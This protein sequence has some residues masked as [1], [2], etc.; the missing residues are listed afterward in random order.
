MALFLSTFFV[1]YG[2][3][4]VYAF[5]KAKAAFAFGIRGAFFLGLLMTVMTLAPLIIRLLE[6]HGYDFQARLL[7]Y[8]GYGWM[9]VLLL[10]CSAGIALDIYRLAVHG[11]DLILHRD[12]VFLRP[13]P[14][15]CFVLPLVCA[16]SIAF[17]GYFEARDIQIERITIRTSGIPKSAGTIRIAQI[18]DVHL[19]LIVREGRLERI[20][21]KVKSAEPHIL[22]STGDLVDGQINGLPGLA[23]RLREIDPL[24]GKYAITGNHEFYAGLPQALE[25]TRQCGFTILRGEGISVAGLINI[26]GVDDPAGKAFGLYRYVPEKELLSSLP[27][28]RFTLLLKHLPIVDGSAAGLFD[29]Q[30]SGHTHKG[31]I[32]PFRFVTR[33]FFRYDSGLFD[34]RDHSRLYV[35]RGTGTW[36]P[37]IRFLA[38]PEVTVYELIPED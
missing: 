19:G 11:A 13:S 20:L 16:V 4:H 38:P 21:E 14:R 34:F 35:S 28:G 36:G 3:M 24:Y 5:L 9:G 12:L 31:Q 7:S 18:S 33:L 32:F 6:R 22:V 29:L 23:E 8:V 17:Y 27:G 30:M 25:F 10:F 1:L 26:A 15:T 37:P 2:V